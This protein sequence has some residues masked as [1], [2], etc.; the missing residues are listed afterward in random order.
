[1]IDWWLRGVLTY[2]MDTLAHTPHNLPAF[3]SNWPAGIPPR[4]GA[5]K[6]AKKHIL[7]PYNHSPGGGANTIFFCYFQFCQNLRF[8]FFC[9]SLRFFLAFFWIVVGKIL[10]E[11]FSTHSQRIF[12][13]LLC[14]HCDPKPTLPP[15]GRVR[16]RARYGQAPITQGNLW[17]GRKKPDWQML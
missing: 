12:K 6:E 15:G 8:V 2:F 7:P 17:V 10:T 9:I 13:G 14:M 16:V 1:M 3:Y 4:R 5:G 11:K